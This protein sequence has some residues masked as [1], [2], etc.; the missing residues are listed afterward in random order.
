MRLNFIVKKDDGCDYHRL[1]VPMQY[2]KGEGVLNMIPHSTTMGDEIYD[3]DILYFNRGINPCAK[4]LVEKRDQYGFKLV[5][6]MDDYWE[7][8]QEHPLYTAWLMNG[9]SNKIVDNLKVAD[10][11]TTTNEQ[12]A[13]EIRKLNPNVEI[14]PNSIPLQD[15]NRRESEKT[16]FI[17]SGSTTHTFDI[18][19][20][21]IPMVKA[22]GEAYIR[23]N[24]QFYLAGYTP[25]IHWDSMARIFDKTGCMSLI[26]RKDLTQYMNAYN[27]ADVSIIPLQKNKFNQKKSILKVQE[28]AA[29]AMPV[30][31]SKVLPYT[32]LMGA[33]GI[34]W[35]E[36][37]ADWL[38]H[39][40]YMI[41][42]KAHIQEMGLELKEYMDK[43]YNFDVINERRYNVLKNLINECVEC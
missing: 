1:I 5:I 13:Q 30:I 34:L 3:C 8:Y 24:S 37:Q 11:I 4:T 23:N 32:E 39:F 38:T 16:R 26:A 40:R 10:L 6:D 15:I 35:V 20:L 41:K 42:N 17:Y 36:K 14:L 31:V 9:L 19:L 18:S 22:G 43:N 33:P 2:M 29:M 27:K 25:G 21:Q 12:L 28:A 7:L